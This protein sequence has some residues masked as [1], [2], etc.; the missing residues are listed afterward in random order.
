M[1]KLTSQ[2][3]K[4][5]AVELELRHAAQAL[6]ALSKKSATAAD[7]LEVL[8]RALKHLVEADRQA[9]PFV[10]RWED[11]A[12]K[13]EK[14]KKD[15][16]PTSIH[17]QI[18]NL[19]RHCLEVAE[20]VRKVPLT[21]DEKAAA[22]KERLLRRQATAEKPKQTARAKKGGLQDESGRV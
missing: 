10:L 1:P 14:V 19:G 2:A 7:A 8:T 17:R 20:R 9:T 5:L 21:V 3:H 15:A 18:A 12:G 13:H 22:Q 4:K 6:R 16:L 11:G